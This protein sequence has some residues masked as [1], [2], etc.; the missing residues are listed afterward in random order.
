MEMPEQRQELSQKTKTWRVARYVLFALLYAVIEIGVTRVPFIASFAS[1]AH[2]DPILGV[3]AAMGMTFALMIAI[4][5]GGMQFNDL[6]G[7]WK[8]Q[9]FGAFA[10]FWSLD[11][12]RTI[13]YVLAQYFSGT[14]QDEGVR[15]IYFFL[16]LLVLMPCEFIAYRAYRLRKGLPVWPNLPKQ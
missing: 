7:E 8:P 2:A 12:C 9:L 15:F 10:F 1:A 3:A 6:T 13:G 16:G 5:I 4:L 14:P 11:T